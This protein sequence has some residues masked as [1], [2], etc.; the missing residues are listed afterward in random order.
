MKPGPIQ[1]TKAPLAFRPGVPQP[2][3]YLD[4][5]AKREYRRVVAEF[6]AAGHE[7]QQIDA[8]VIEVY[9]QGLADFRRLTLELR[10]EGEVLVSQSGY[11][12]PHPKTSLKAQAYKQLLAAASKLGFS[13]ADRQ[14]IPAPK[15]GK[16]GHD[17]DSFERV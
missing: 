2:A 9:A 12:Q 17:G 1:R 14:R 16:A 5:A 13:P 8:A 11:S 10:A 3:A 15:A 7:L 6:E 4:A